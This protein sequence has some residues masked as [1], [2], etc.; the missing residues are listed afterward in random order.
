MLLQLNDALRL[1]NL[2]IPIVNH[3]RPPAHSAT[4]GWAL[5]LEVC[6][7]IC[8]HLHRVTHPPQA[9]LFIIT[10][11][12]QKNRKSETL[13]ISCAWTSWNDTDH[14]RDK[15]SAVSKSQT[16]EASA[17]SKHQC[18]AGNARG[19]RC[20]DLWAGENDRFVHFYFC[21]NEVLNKATDC[22]SH[23]SN[24][25]RYIKQLANNGNCIS[26]WAEKCWSLMPSSALHCGLS[27]FLPLL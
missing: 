9:M 13:R 19:M 3:L 24:I 25:K 20:D 10:S 4:C 6:Q 26:W 21:L 7:S 27:V 1:F 14:R 22:N 18:C 16:I 8:L 5:D 23:N 12:T 2:N 15:T 17:A 11:E